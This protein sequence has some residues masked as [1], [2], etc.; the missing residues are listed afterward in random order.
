[1][2]VNLPLIPV[3]WLLSLLPRPTPWWVQAP[4]A[5][6]AAWFGWWAIV[7]FFERRARDAGPVTPGI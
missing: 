1:M 3:V 4:T 5:A 2:V 6:A 7:I